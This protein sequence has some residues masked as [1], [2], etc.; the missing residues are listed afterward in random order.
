MRSP[1]IYVTQPLQLG[2]PL[3][4]SGSQA[5]HLGRVLRVKKGETVTLFNG[6]G[7]QWQATVEQTD[8]RSV[9]VLPHTHNND[10]RESGL[11]IILGQV[12]SRGERMDYAIQKSVETGVSRIVPLFSQRCEVHLNQERLQKRLQH[13][14]SLII[15]TCE[16]CGRNRIPDICV[17]TVLGEWLDHCQADR[18]YVLHPPP[19]SSER[20]PSASMAMAQESCPASVALLIGPEGG[21]D[22]QELQQS[23][24]AGFDP[25]A[26]GPRVLRT[27]TAPV[28]AISIL[29]YLWG[30]WR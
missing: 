25:L 29:Q 17:P 19:P 4:L 3:E 10:D 13:W 23:Q 20:Q 14:Q 1:R 9:R 18:K 26:L 27:E 24:K 15:S 8:R 7:G 5:N 28:A 16:Q 2:L 12:L 6:E 11:Q 30:D 22:C 21:F